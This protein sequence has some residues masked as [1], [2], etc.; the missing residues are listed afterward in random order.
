[1]PTLAPVKKLDW[2]VQLKSS[3]TKRLVPIKQSLSELTGTCLRAQ[4]G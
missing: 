1:M 4:F 3:A 2:T